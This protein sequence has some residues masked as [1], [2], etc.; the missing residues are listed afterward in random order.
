MV[1][2]AIVYYLGMIGLLFWGIK[3]RKNTKQEVF[4]KEETNFIKGIAAI[5]VVLAHSHEYLQ[6]HGQAAS[7]LA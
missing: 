4:T 3:V 2:I 7:I 5:M 1:L 6:N